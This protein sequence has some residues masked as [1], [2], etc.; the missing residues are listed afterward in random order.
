MLRSLLFIFTLFAVPLAKAADEQ[1]RY[2]SENVYVY[3]HSGP[4]SQYKI[5][6][7]VAAGQ[8]IR[9]L[10]ESADGY[11]K[12]VDNKGREGW[13][14]SKSITEKQSFRF[15]IPELEKEIAQ[16]TKSLATAQAQE[17]SYNDGLNKIKQQLADEQQKRVV[18]EQELVAAQNE[19]S[20]LK[21]DTKYQFWREGGMIA[22]AGLL[23]GLI[24]AYLPRPTRR[25]R[26]NW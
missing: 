15:V 21:A 14:T 10:P 6:G 23:L 3:L 19:L 25:K 8:E 13:V 2:V 18:I 17:A 9:L 16:L 26:T 12:I 7:S 20:E 24:L 4:G 22:G 5:L 1:V 11:S